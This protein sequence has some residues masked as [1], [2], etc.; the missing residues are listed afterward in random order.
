MDRLEIVAPGASGEA[1]FLEFGR[2]WLL[3]SKIAKMAMP[4]IKQAGSQY[5]L[6]KPLSCPKNGE[7][8]NLGDRLLPFSRFKSYLGLERRIVRFPHTR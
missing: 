8:L 6:F 3:N 2:K 7:T 1:V 4:R 5:T